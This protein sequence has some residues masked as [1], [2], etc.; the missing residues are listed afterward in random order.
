MKLNCASRFWSNG[1]KT[2]ATFR[3]PCS[4]LSNI[5]RVYQE[6]PSKRFL[7]KGYYVRSKIYFVAAISVDADEEKR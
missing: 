2:K 4:S 7:T 6:F 3:S 1:C 5:K